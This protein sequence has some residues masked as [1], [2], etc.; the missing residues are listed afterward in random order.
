MPKGAC[1]SRVSRAVNG[2]MVEVSGKQH[3]SGLGAFVWEQGLDVSSFEARSCKMSIEIL[4]CLSEFLG[5]NKLQ[6][7]GY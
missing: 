7:Q 1:R 2:A 4:S 3:H 6:P 5:S